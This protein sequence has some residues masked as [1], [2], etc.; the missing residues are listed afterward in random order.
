MSRSDQPAHERVYRHLRARVLQGDL[1]PGQAVTLRGVAE[2]LGVSVTPA[3]EAMR[4]LI[5][6]RALAAT[7]TGRILAPQRDAAA[8]SELLAARRLLEPDLAA[9]ALPHADA[10][11][12]KALRAE[13]SRVNAALRDGD[14]AAYVSANASFHRKLYAAAQAPALLALVESVWLQLNPSMRVING[15]RGTARL[16]DQHEAAIAALAARDESALRAAVTADILQAEAALLDRAG[17]TAD[18]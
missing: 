9:R 15:Q 8:L 18:G 2:A 4:R 17:A 6:E 11:L 10:A 14:A 5:A 1:A 3:R 16:V 13:D 7:E 12:L